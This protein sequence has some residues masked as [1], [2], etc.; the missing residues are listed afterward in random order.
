MKT[1]LSQIR[2]LIYVSMF[3]PTQQIMHGRRACPQCLEKGVSQI[4]HLIYVSIFI[5][6]Q[7]I[8]HGRRACPQCL[9]KGVSQI[10]NLIYYLCL[11]LLTPLCEAGGPVSY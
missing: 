8:M 6:T 9:E 3:I 2:H 5:P 7:Q 1:V 11:R 10:S 4:S